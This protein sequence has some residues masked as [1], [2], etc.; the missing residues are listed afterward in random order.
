M[1]GTMSLK[2]T[3]MIIVPG[4]A[5]VAAVLLV[6]VVYLWSIGTLLPY[7]TRAYRGDGTITDSGF[8]THP[9][10][11][12]SMPEIL[13]TET[14]QIAYSLKNVPRADFGFCLQVQSINVQG[15]RVPPDNFETVR[16]DLSVAIVITITDAQGNTVYASSSSLQQWQMA[17][18]ID[19]TY[20]WLDGYV[21]RLEHGQRYRLEFDVTVERASGAHV[22]VK[23]F[24]VGGGSE[25]P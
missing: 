19:R 15:R 23:P 3:R 14:Q 20:L 16:N 5:I 10:Y 12:I 22:I 7:D 1:L 21:I 18:S 4:I 25:L 9:R 11:C 17:K 13:L 6:A 2:P 8:W 24:L